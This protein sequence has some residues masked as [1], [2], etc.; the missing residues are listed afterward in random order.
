MSLCL[1]E[2]DIVWIRD[3]VL[4]GEV[5]RTQLSREL[6]ERKGWV[7]RMGRHREMGARVVLGRLNR[8]FLIELPEVKRRVPSSKNVRI[9]KEVCKGGSFSISDFS[10][11]VFCAQEV[12][13]EVVSSRDER[14]LWRELME[15]YHYLGSGPLCGSQLKYLVYLRGELVGGLSFSAAAYALEARDKRIGWSDEARKQNLD[16][17]IC[18]SHFLLTSKIPNLASHVLSRVISRLPEDWNIRYGIRPLLVETF[19]EKERFSGTC[20]RAANWIYVGDTKGRGRNDS[21]RKSNLPIKQIFLIPLEPLWHWQ[22]K[23]CQGP[24]KKLKEEPKQ[25]V[26]WAAWEFGSVDL[27]DARLTARLVTTAEDFFQKPTANIPQACGSRAKTKAVYRLCSSP[28]ATMDNLLSDHAESTLSRCAKESRV[29]A[30][31]DTTTLN[32]TTH[33]A[34]TELGPIGSSGADATLGLLLHTTFMLNEADTPLGLLHVQCWAR[35][36]DP[37]SYGKAEQRYDIPI[38]KKESYKW[39][40]GFHATA[41]AAKRAPNTEFVMMGDRES[42]IFELFDAQ[43]KSAPENLQIL[44]RACQPRKIHLHSG[45]NKYLWEHVLEQPIS[46]E[47]IVAVPRSGKR[48]ARQ[49]CLGLHFAEVTICPPDKLKKRKFNPVKLFAIAAVEVDPPQDVEPLQW[50]LLCTKPV[51]SFAE[52]QEKVKWYIKR[53]NIEVFHRTLKSGCEIENRQLQSAHNIKAALSIDLV[54]AWRIF[55]LAKLGREVPDAPCTIFFAE[56]E[57]KALSCFTNKTPVPPKQPPTLKNALF[58]VAT[59]GGFLG[60]KRDGMPGTQTLWRGL[61]RLADISEA[62]AVFFNSS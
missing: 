5:T 29:F 26:S 62:C 60:R 55:H 18:N 48:P 21:G 56:N 30:I 57:W 46:G 13:L 16:R 47:M 24:A 22:R 12:T 52:A 51:T 11:S 27:G 33:H 19:V 40:K 15:Q 14:L 38:E 28:A 25:N 44:I 10:T 37:E 7:D 39:L 17:V 8:K 1:E 49:A 35:S 54:V 34:T 9:L 42:D 61:E 2:S 41:E 43:N 3:R 20:Y 36:T 50:L 59:L 6:C 53:W 31:Q 4:S 23:L 32:Y 45:E 58:M